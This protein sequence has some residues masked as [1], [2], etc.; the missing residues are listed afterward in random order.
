[1]GI[2]RSEGWWIKEVMDIL[3]GKA[4]FYYKQCCGDLPVYRSERGEIYAKRE[5][6]RGIIGG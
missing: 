6:G 5:E 2:I 3:N 1:M 4:P